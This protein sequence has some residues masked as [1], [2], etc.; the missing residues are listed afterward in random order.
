MSHPRTGGATLEPNDVREASVLYM[1]AMTS[2]LP[3]GAVALRFHGKPCTT[4]DAK[5]AATLARVGAQATTHRTV[6]RVFID[7]DFATGG[8][9]CELRDPSSLL[10][11]LPSRK[12]RLQRVAMLAV[13]LVL[14][15]T[16]ER[17]H[18]SIDRATFPSTW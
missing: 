4:A 6:G 2:L 12:L 13:A 16:L 7:V 17:R 1:R 3:P 18:A 9:S 8:S 10:V 5:L 15:V 11:R 14:L